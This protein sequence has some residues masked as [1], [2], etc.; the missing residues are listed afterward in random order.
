M[1]WGWGL[2]S[3][4][5]ADRA[6]CQQLIAL[7][8]VDGAGCAAVARRTDAQRNHPVSFWLD[9][10]VPASGGYL[11]YSA[12]TDDGSVRDADH[13]VVRVGVVDLDFLDEPDLEG[14]SRGLSA[15]ASNST[16]G[17]NLGDCGARHIRGVPVPSVKDTSVLTLPWALPPWSRCPLRSPCRCGRGAKCGCTHPGRHW[18]PICLEVSTLL[19][20]PRTES[21][22]ATSTRCLR[23]LKLTHSRCRWS[24]IRSVSNWSAITRPNRK[25]YLR[26]SHRRL[27]IPIILSALTWHLP[28]R[29]YLMLEVVPSGRQWPMKQ[30]SLAASA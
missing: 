16:G 29:T 7:G 8:G 26:L 30:Q 4:Q 2:L 19:S 11:R 20:G 13:V 14:V 9:R 6:P 27:L 23:P 28:T 10:Q 17:I 1:D 15:V 3:S 22:S 12:G 5:D 25:L 21:L 24:T 18:R